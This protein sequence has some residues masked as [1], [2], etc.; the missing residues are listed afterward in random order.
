[1]IVSDYLGYLVS[2]VI[3]VMSEDMNG[4]PS[5]LF[6]KRSEMD[7][8]VYG[9]VTFYVWQHCDSTYVSATETRQSLCDVFST[10]TFDHFDNSTNFARDSYEESAQIDV[11][12]CEKVFEYPLYSI[13]GKEHHSLIQ[14]LTSLANVNDHNAVLS[15]CFLS[16]QVNMY[17]TFPFNH[18]SFFHYQVKYCYVRASA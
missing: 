9:N 1:M 3:P 10:Q 17:Y 8:F 11:M 4:H 16:N 12:F 18:F 14:N 5:S 2:D 6:I 7:T 13:I 15:Y